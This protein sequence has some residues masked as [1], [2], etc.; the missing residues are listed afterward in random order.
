MPAGTN[1]KTETRTAPDPRNYRTAPTTGRH[2]ALAIGSTSAD[3]GYRP[4]WRAAF[5]YSNDLRKGLLR[6]RA[7]LPFAAMPRPQPDD[8]IAPAPRAVFEAAPAKPGA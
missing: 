7:N 2:K 3:S 1:R 8:A 5:A 6:R 4:P